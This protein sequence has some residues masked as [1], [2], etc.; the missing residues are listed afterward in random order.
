MFFITKGAASPTIKF[1]IIGAGLAGLSSIIS[2][3]KRASAHPNVHFEIDVIEKRDLNF[4]RGQKIIMIDDPTDNKGLN[5]CDFCMRVFYPG[6]S[7]ALN[8]KGD[9]LVD[10]KIPETNLRYKVVQKILRQKTQEAPPVN[11][12]IKQLQKALLDQINDSLPNNVK[13]KW[14]LKSTVTNLDVK[15]AT[16]LVYSEGGGIEKVLFQVLLD[17]EGGKRQTV[18]IINKAVQ[19]SGLPPFEY[20]MLERVETYHMAIKIKLDNPRSKD[21]RQLM[22][23]EA[24]KYGKDKAKQERVWTFLT[25][26]VDINGKL[27]PINSLP[28]IIDP[29]VYKENFYTTPWIPKYF[30]ASPI[31][32]AIHDILDQPTKRE[33]LLKWASYMLANYYGIGPENFVIDTKDQSEKAMRLRANTFTSQINAVKNP[34]LV[35]PNQSIIGVLGDAAMSSYYWKGISSLI[36]LNEVLIFLDCIF[37]ANSS[38]SP[39]N[40]ADSLEKLGAYMKGFFKM[41]RHDKNPY[42]KFIKVYTIYKNYIREKLDLN[43]VELYEENSSSSPDPY[44]SPIL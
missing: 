37:E 17:C 30:M 7:L 34:I 42:D 8:S 39:S 16:L 22:K 31:P 28:A 27:I 18:H 26:L 2:I 10:G 32:K 15:T 1:A 38:A 5:W 29:N 43:P 41:K 36:C 11:L 21:Y 9:L 3:I 24:K 4:N 6:K 23:E 44:Y 13:I 12:S 35:L 33:T 25:T 40:T 19:E 20:E 14:H